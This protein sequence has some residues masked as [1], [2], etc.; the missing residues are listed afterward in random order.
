MGTEEDV[1]DIES[2][3]SDEQIHQQIGA[4]MMAMLLQLDREI[5]EIIEGHPE[6][7][8]VDEDPSGWVPDG[9]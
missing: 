5:R 7:E 4:W 1:L 2:S 6:I 3:P 8:W 9:T